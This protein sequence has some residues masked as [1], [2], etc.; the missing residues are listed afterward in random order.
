MT[1]S[2]HVVETFL[3]AFARHDLDDAVAWLDPDV[4]F[5]PSGHEL[6]PSRGDYSGRD[7]FRRW[8]GEEIPRGFAT[9][10]I[11]IVELDD[12]R[13]LAEVESSTSRSGQL[14]RAERAVV[15]TITGGLISAIE[16]FANPDDAYRARALVEDAD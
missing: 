8:W 11:G 14:V 15:F 16:V 6:A 1:A 5:V 9:T 4:Y 12:A 7:G 13:V 10:P 3:A 2:L